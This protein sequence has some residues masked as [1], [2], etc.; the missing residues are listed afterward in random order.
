[1]K[2]AFL[3]PSFFPKIGG[4]EIQLEILA[5]LLQR[6]G[7]DVHV[8]APYY[9]YKFN[10]KSFI[11]SLH[12][13]ATYISNRAIGCA[14]GDYPIP[15]SITGL[16]AKIRAENQRSPFDLFV[17]YSSYKY[18]N[19]ALGLRR[20][21]GKPVVLRTHGADINMVPEIKYGW[22]LDP[23][24]A[25]LIEQSVR[26]ADHCIAISES[27]V[28]LQREIRGDSGISKIWNGVDVKK[29]SPRSH[30]GA[31]VQ[32]DRAAVGILV[33]R[34][35]P[36]KQFD[37]FLLAFSKSEILKQKMK[38]RLVG[39]GMKQL[40]SLCHEHGIAEFVELIEGVDAESMPELYRS[41]DVFIMPSRMETFGTVTVEAMA[42]GLPV[43][44]LDAP[45]TTDQIVDGKTGFLAPT[46]D[47]M[48]RRLEEMVDAPTQMRTFAGA[49]R[50]RAVSSFSWDAVTAQYEAVF[51]KTIDD[52]KNPTK[53]RS[54]SKVENYERGHVSFQNIDFMVIEIFFLVIKKIK[55]Y[56][57]KLNK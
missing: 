13:H 17:A 37:G 15:G 39:R 23:K 47:D 12:R 52:F 25:L 54:H 49:G 55:F 4:M 29:F 42:S 35:A 56:F 38:I 57:R 48:V 18:G 19:V 26:Q 22:R 34:N 9:S 7:I 53:S 21:Y 6:R 51:Q 43:V 33:G 50:K 16:G 45:G 30:I 14:I 28:Q 31:G 5:C 41:A 32:S 11:F 27:V 10:E 2:I 40:A 1:M 20:L 46:L 24:K 8:F 44:G 36:K 3:T